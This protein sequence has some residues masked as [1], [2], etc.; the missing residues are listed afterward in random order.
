ME[1]VVFMRSTLSLWII[2]VSLAALLDWRVAMRGGWCWPN[3]VAAWAS[4]ARSFGKHVAHGPVLGAGGA[5]EVLLGDL[6]GA[7]GGG[8]E[9]R[10]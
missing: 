6:A 1:E 7:L 9:R 5:A 10:R 4:S 3:S 8:E 2:S